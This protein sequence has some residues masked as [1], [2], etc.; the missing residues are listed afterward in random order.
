[1]SVKSSAFRWA[2]N[3]TALTFRC[4]II[5]LLVVLF[6]C[7]GA[8]L[9]YGVEAAK[10]DASA[11]LYA[12]RS[13]WPMTLCD[14]RQRYEQWWR[15]QMDGLDMSPWY[16]ASSPPKQLKD[17]GKGGLAQWIDLEEKNKDAKPRWRVR[18][19][20]IDGVI[21]Y[22]LANHGIS[23]QRVLPVKT[24][25]ECE[26]ADSSGAAEP[27]PADAG[28]CQDPIEIDLKN[29]PMILQV[30]TITSDRA[31]KITAWVSAQNGLELWLNGKRVFANHQLGN[32]LQPKADQAQVALDLKKGDNQLVMR[33]IGTRWEG[34]YFSTVGRALPSQPQP[35]A[36]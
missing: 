13:S 12:K 28:Q 29:L 16:L 23:T 17:A 15:R 36:Q 9:A 27:S 25:A 4:R 34:F 20:L 30:R 8:S 7:Q 31:K 1:M 18:R 19:D 10:E 22:D 2:A 35:R 21:H 32:G 26:T 24:V 14:S 5:L 33:L 3:L 11:S 6:C